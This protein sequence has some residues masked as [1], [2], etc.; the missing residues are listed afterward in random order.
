MQKKIN[1][2]VHGDGRLPSGSVRRN[3]KNHQIGVKD[4]SKLDPCTMQSAMFH[5]RAQAKSK[6]EGIWGSNSKNLDKDKG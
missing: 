4:G 5:Y 1:Q 3:Q 2:E 6:I